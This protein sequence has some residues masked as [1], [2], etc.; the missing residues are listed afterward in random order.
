MAT[1]SHI[2]GWRISWIESLVGYSPQGRRRVRHNLATKHH[3]L[4]TPQIQGQKVLLTEG[5]VFIIQSPPQGFSL[6]I[7]FLGGDPWSG[8]V[9]LLLHDQPEWR[10]GRQGP[11][12]HCPRRQTGKKKQADRKVH[13]KWVGVRICSLLKARGARPQ[14]E[15]TNKEME[16]NQMKSF[17][18]KDGIN[19]SIDRQ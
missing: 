12:H 13:L 10:P 7:R 16:S 17:K 8:E 11:G 2:F 3:H 1:H 6:L 18:R 19:K 15:K 4:D 5:L 9:A 14:G